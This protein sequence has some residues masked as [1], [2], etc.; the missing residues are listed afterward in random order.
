MAQT[1]APE[2]ALER[3]MQLFA[4][5][6]APA[7]APPRSDHPGV[8]SYYDLTYAVVPG[9]RP[10]ALDLHVPSSGTGFPVLVWVHGGGWARGHRL[11][12]QAV[13]LVQHG[14]AVAATQYRLSGEAVHP[15][16]L[17]D[18]KG[19]VRWL[20]ASAD[21]FGL[22]SE[23]IAGWG[24]SAGGHLV[25]LLGLTGNRPDLAGDVGGNTDQSSA[26]QAVVAYFPV[27]DFFA[28]ATGDAPRPGPNPLNAFLG[29]SLQERPDDAR[30]AMPLTFVH[31]D[32]P[33]FLLLHG[34]VDPMV[35]HAQ[36]ELLNAALQKA[37]ARSELITLPGA[38][39]E[40][41]AFWSDE[42]LSNVRAF[43]D[44]ALRG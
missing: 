29:Y 32:A 31:K 2:N 3:Q 43:L 4:A 25:S 13:K 16:Q 42:T 28:M 21:R 5:L 9:F 22:D 10:L 17:Q 26:V 1:Q 14:Y 7:P 12:G 41:P 23:H 38:L 37:G 11:M 6:E 20:R 44:S 18:L 30:Q 34:D 8:T 35:P 33:P 27:T 19:A 39:H 15:A 36:S 40:D 24:A